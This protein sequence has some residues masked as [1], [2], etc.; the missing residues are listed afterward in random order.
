V[1]SQ[2]H[3]ALIQRV[4]DAHPYPP[5]IHRALDQLLGE[6]TAGQIQPLVGDGGPWTQWGR[7]YFGESWFDVPFFW[8]E[9]YFYRKLLEATAF[10]TPGPWRGIDPFAPMKAAELVDPAMHDE[11]KWIDTIGG[12]TPEDRSTAIVRAALW[13]NRADLGFQIAHPQ[14]A[15]A[16]TGNA[17]VVDDSDVMEQLL[18]AGAPGT[19]C[20]IA[21][22]AGRELLPDLILVDHLL[23]TGRAARVEVHVKP[24]PYFV[25]DA[26]TA[27]LIACVRLLVDAGGEAAAVGRR[28]WKAIGEGHVDI[29]AD[30]FYCAPLTFHDMPATLAKHFRTAKVTIFKGDLNYRRLLGDSQWPATSSFAELTDYFPGPVVALRTLKSEVVVGLT[31]EQLSSLDAA[32]D[33]WRT[34]GTHALIAARI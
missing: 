4:R 2:R 9:S 18:D 29:Q 7:P 16:D 32:E 25:S 21:D 3:P 1:L 19:V 34:A 26:T 6:I 10:F 17:L 31:A 22:N 13:G 14:S 11:L 12:M 20:L 27:D 28:L 33:N 8:A 5:A 15:R 30:P 24:Y 23:R